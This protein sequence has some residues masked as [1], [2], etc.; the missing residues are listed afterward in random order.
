MED[1]IVRVIAR[2]V[3][4]FIQLY[5]VYV[6]FNGHISPGGGFAG[7][8]ILGSSM[9][10]FALAFNLEGGSKK[11]SH[12]ASTLLESGGAL[13]F[14]ILGLIG[15]ILGSNYLSNADAGFP[16]GTAG[17]LFSSGLIFLATLAIGVKVAS[18]VITLF[19]NLVEGKTHD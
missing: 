17:N 4:P 7:G 13:W 9:L 5:G 11:I 6:I 8:A 1:I 14:G 15:I 16:L 18:T 2:L 3:V 10:L 19:Y 12:D